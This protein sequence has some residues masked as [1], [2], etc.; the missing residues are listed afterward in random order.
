MILEFYLYWKKLEKRE[1]GKKYVYYFEWFLKLEL[2]YDID[3][4]CKR[5]M[6]GKRSDYDV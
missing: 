3:F 6:C 2:K 1:I 5:D 4:C